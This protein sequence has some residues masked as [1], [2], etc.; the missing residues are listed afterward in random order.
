MCEVDFTFEHD[1]QVSIEFWGLEAAHLYELV[2][3]E[4][5]GQVGVPVFVDAKVYLLF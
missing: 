4:L 2:G 3:D 1:A 5:R